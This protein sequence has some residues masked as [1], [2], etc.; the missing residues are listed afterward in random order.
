MKRSIVL[1]KA[2]SRRHK[3]ALTDC[4][5]VALAALSFMVV[6]M[7]TGVHAQSSSRTG[8]VRQDVSDQTN[9]FREDRHLP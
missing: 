3:S 6:A 2:L 1:P 4:M 8:L 7:A 5:L 9:Q